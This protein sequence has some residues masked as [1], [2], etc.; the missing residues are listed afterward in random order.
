MLT[1]SWEEIDNNSTAN[2]LGTGAK[3]FFRSYT[4]VSSPSRMFPNL[5]AVLTGATSDLGDYLPA[6]AQTLNFR[7]K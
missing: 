5:S 3:P 7:H 2:A 1:Y 4:P 6:T